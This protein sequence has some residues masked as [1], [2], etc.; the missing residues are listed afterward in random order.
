[1]HGS[2]DIRSELLLLAE[3]KYKKFMSVLLPTVKSE[4][5]VGV[6]VPM[7]RKIAKRTVRDG[8]YIEHLSRLPHELYEEDAIHAFILCELEYGECVSE[9]ARFLPYVDSWGICDSIRPK[10]FASHKKELIG[11]ISKWLKSEDSYVKRFAIEM[12]MVHF[13]GEDFRIE[14]FDT[15]SAIRSE[16]Y[17]LNMMIAWYF[18]TALAERYEQALPY[19]ENRTLSVWVHNKAISKANESLRI[20]PEKKE[21]LKT[22]RI[23]KDSV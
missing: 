8:S 16:E 6:R 12:L 21:Y 23:R 18:A 7:L 14:F 5:I 19:I 1:M 15:V 10:C 22:L 9:L 2:L 4:R 17:Y 13:L 20:S 11:E 3:E